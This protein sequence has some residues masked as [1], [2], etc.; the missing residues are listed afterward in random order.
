MPG[1]ASGGMDGVALR[2]LT[3]AFHE[4]GFIATLNGEGAQSDKLHWGGP[5]NPQALNRYSYVQNNP[6]R[7]TDPSGHC[8]ACVAIGWAL[9]GAGFTISAPFV[10]AIAGVVAVGAIAVFLSDANNRAWLS[11]Q[12]RGGVGNIDGFV[13]GLTGRVESA[14]NPTSASTQNNITAPSGLV[15]NPNRPGSW[16]KHDGRNGKFREYWRLDKGEAG[17]PGWGGEDHVHHYG[18]KKHL[19]PDTPFDPDAPHPDDVTS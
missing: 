14:S 1:N 16:G 11:E 8:P 9:T 2:P 5:S 4:P 7:W 13:K 6:M 10:A 17:A 3:V 19:D 12:I 15:E 18:G